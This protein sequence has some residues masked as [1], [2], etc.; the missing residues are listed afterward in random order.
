[1]SRYLAGLR[2]AGLV[3]T[4]RNGLWVHYRL[5]PPVDPAMAAVLALVLEVAAAQDLKPAKAPAKTQ[6]L[7]P[8]GTEPDFLD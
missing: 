6:V 8:P 2:E 5:N 4:R 7:P 3:S 1:M